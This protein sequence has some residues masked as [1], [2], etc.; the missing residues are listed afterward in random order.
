MMIDFDKSFDNY[1][2]KWYEEKKDSMTMDEMEEYMPSLYEEWQNAPNSE[3]DGVSPKAYF[4]QIKDS[5][6]AI[7]MLVDFGSDGNVPALLLDKIVELGCEKE[8]C[9]LICGDYSAEIK[10]QAL[11]LLQECGAK[12]PTEDCVKIMADKTADEG[13]RELCVEILQS[14]A[15]EVKNYLFAMIPYADYE[16]KGLIVE[17]LLEADYDERTSNLLIDLFENY[18]NKALYAG[19]MGKYG[20]ENFAPVLYKALDGCNYADYMEIRNAI[21]QLGGTVDDDYRDFSSDPYY[22]ALKNVK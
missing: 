22:M 17:I 10:I 6:S 21:E 1:L 18:D 16:L 13:L 8:L 4:D 11:N 19:F 3:L 2:K 12:I 20:D 5:K 15:N 9:A 7:D 14:Q